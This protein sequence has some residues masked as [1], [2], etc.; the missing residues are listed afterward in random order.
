MSFLK[1]KRVLVTGGTGSFGKAF[2]EHALAAGCSNIVIFS[3]DE[4]KQHELRIS[5]A[6][7]D[8]SRIRFF[9]GDCRDVKRL[10]SAFYGVD[11]VIHAAALKHVSSGEYNPSEVINTNIDGTINVFN[12]ALS[13]G[14]SKLVA[15]STDKASS[16]VNLY[17]ATKLVGD[18]FL[19]AVANAYHNRGLE[20]SVVRY[21]NVAGSR[22]SIIP[23]LL[24]KRANNESVVSITDL[25][26]SRF[27][28]SLKQGVQL[29]DMAIQE[30]SVGEIFIPKIPSVRLETIVN[31][32]LPDSNIKLIGPQPGEKMHEELLSAEEARMALD[33]GT[34]YRLYSGGWASIEEMSRVILEGHADKLPHDFRYTSDTNHWFLNDSQLATFLAES[35]LDK[36][37]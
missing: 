9:L 6:E 13:C 15:L 31:T 26:M 19:A 35:G 30:G 7:K 18:K 10:E 11:V 21:G 28:I 2:L 14:V 25:S 4:L 5:L 8:L 24:S 17:G 36:G 23:L 3:R 29:V 34:H 20:I 32:I 27:L 12:A 22:G 33:F 1:G 16:P 37:R